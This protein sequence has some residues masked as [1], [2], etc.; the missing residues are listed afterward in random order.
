MSWTR[1]AGVLW[2]QAVRVHG[3]GRFASLTGC[4]GVVSVVLFEKRSECIDW[5][6]S[7]EV[8][9]RRCAHLH[10]EPSDM[11]AVATERLAVVRQT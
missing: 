11:V 4:D 2:P 1:L 10:E 6:S 9:C 3:S 5:L 7:G 8:C